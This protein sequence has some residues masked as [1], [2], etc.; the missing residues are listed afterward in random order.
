VID[1][2]LNRALRISDKTNLAAEIDHVK[3]ILKQNGYPEELISSRLAI[4][5]KRKKLKHKNSNT[6]DTAISKPERICLPFMGNLTNRISRTLSRKGNFTTAY[7]PGQKIE[8]FFNAHKD[9]RPKTNNAV[10]YEIK[11]QSCPQTYIGQTKREVEIRMKEHL[12][13]IKHARTDKSAVASHVW[14]SD[15]EHIIQ[16]DD[17]RIIEKE[18]RWYHRNFKEALWIQKTGATAMNQDSGWKINPIWTSLII[19]TLNIPPRI[20]DT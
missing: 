3:A 1:S 16:K 12:A 8:S 15:G 20:K 2:L 4:C 5:K 17:I 19:P 7:K 18:A 9:K 10:I 11:C 14:L 6:I 13:D